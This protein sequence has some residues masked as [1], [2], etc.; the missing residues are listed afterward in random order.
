VDDPRAG[1]FTLVEVVVAMSILALVAGGITA[2]FRMTARSMERG[3]EAVH[4]AAVQRA[5]LAVLE[6]AF[7]N[8]SPAPVPGD[9]GAGIFFRGTRDRVTLLSVSPAAGGSGGALRLVTFREG[10]SP[11]GVAGLTAEE[12]SPFAAGSGAG[13]AK[14]GPARVVFPGASGLAFFYVAGFGNDGRME[15]EEA[16]DAGERKRLPAA[17]GIEFD[18]EGEGARRRVVVPIPTG[19]NQLPDRRPP[20][21]TGPIE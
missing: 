8:A 7:R 20:L 1:G 3:E 6:R 18:V 19:V 15:S 17:V 9:N 13:D 5:R 4:G 12:R 11:S 21:D 16:W 10:R 14:D 2:A